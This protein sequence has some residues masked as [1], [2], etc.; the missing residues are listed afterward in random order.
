MFPPA[1]FSFTIAL[2]DHKQG[3]VFIDI[4]LLAFRLPQKQFSS[5][6]T[7]LKCFEDCAP[8]NSPPPPDLAWSC[9]QL[10]Q[11]VLYTHMV[12]GPNAD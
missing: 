3:K 2:F 4:V 8:Q 1:R 12:I 11:D 7:M 6:G 9:S 10:F 5:T